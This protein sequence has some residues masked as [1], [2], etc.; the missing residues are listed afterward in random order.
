MN[1]QARKTNAKRWYERDNPQKQRPTTSL[2]LQ[3]VGW[4]LR[5][6]G[7]CVCGRERNFF[8]EEVGVVCHVLSSPRLP[9][10]TSSPVRPFS[11]QHGLIRVNE[12]RF[13]YNRQYRQKRKLRQLYITHEDVAFVSRIALGRHDSSEESAMQLTINHPPSFQNYE[14]SLLFILASDS[15]SHSMSCKSHYLR[16]FCGCTQI[17]V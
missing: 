13:F 4:G 9:P 10:V 2:V 3:L 14:P 5:M 17:S 6:L 12:C 11:R 15:S 1:Y 16:F 7:V 8:G